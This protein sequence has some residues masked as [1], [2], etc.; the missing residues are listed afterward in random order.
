[1]TMSDN[2][3]NGS[4]HAEPALVAEATAPIEKKITNE[5]RLEIE[6]LIMKV[7]NMVLQ[8]QAM[9]RDIIESVKQ[10]QA[11][12]GE[13][14]QIQKKLSAKYNIDMAKVEIRPDG[15]IV[16]KTPTQ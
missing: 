3:V 10:R 8:Q 12:Q 5:E 16:E 13:L 1:M 9:Q 7:Q 6:V 14:E 4:A 15:T 2:A 11:Y